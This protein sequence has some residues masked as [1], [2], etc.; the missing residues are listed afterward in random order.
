[1]ADNLGYTPGTGANVA[2]DDVDGVQYQRI[3]LT[4]GDD[5]VNNGDVSA[6]NPMPVSE[7]GPLLTLFSRLLNLLGSPVGYDKSLQRQRGTVVVESGTV[8]TVT[9]VTTVTTATTVGTVNNQLAIGGIQA[10][11]LPNS[12]NLAAWQ[13]SVRSRI[14]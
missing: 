4:M 7:S 6:N 5:G 3:K 8:N 13:A 1:M 10:Q 9:T 11:I 2:T 14:S 12:A